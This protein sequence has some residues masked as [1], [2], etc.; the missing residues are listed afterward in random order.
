MYHLILKFPW[1]DADS[2]WI[3]RKICD[4]FALTSFYAWFVFGF[5]WYASWKFCLL[6]LFDWKNL[7]EKNT[8]NSQW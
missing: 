3:M 8:I 1:Q 7:S 6:E 4:L 5:S 2:H